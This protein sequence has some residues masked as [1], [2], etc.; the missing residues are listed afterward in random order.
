MQKNAQ[1]YLNFISS[2]DEKS[3]TKVIQFNADILNLMDDDGDTV[4]HNIWK[5]S[6]LKLFKQL[7]EKFKEEIDFN[8]LNNLGVNTLS[9]CVYQ[10]D[11]STLELLLTLPKKDQVGG[12]NLFQLNNKNYSIFDLATVHHDCII[13]KKL[14]EIEIPTNHIKKAMKAASINNNFM[15]MALLEKKLIAQSLTDN[16]KESKKTKI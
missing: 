16:D 6:K 3:I 2:F 5:F 15:A 8:H 14:L 4:F 7:F 9:L 12:I 11:L 10:S 1:Y 13:L